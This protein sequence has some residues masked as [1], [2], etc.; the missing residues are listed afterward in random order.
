MRYL[1]ILL[2]VAF[3]Q[4]ASS[5][6]NVKQADS[7]YRISISKQTM[8]LTLYDSDNQI[9]KRY[10][11]ACGK[12]YGNKVKVGDLRTPE[13][14]FT[15]QEIVNSS[16]WQHDFKDGKGMI[17]GAYGPYFIRLTTPPH[18]G[19]GIHGTHDDASIGTRATEGCIRMHNS[20]LRELRPYVKVGMNVEILTS[21][22]DKAASGNK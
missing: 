22:A 16:H 5:Q 14:N 18:R 4:V 20:D 10:P 7:Q 19:I 15:V 9:V 3:A 6:E 1:F 2:F 8:E 11:I 12:N 21:E 17:P 13:G